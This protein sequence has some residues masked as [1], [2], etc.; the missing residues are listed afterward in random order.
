MIF[1]PAIYYY[2]GLN[3]NDHWDL[4]MVDVMNNCGNL[5]GIKYLSIV[6][7]FAT[8]MDNRIY[9]KSGKG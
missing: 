1:W 7:A 2:N 6:P 8:V 5:L 3:L 4:Q 9:L